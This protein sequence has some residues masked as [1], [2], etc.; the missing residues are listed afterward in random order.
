MLPQVYKIN[1]HLDVS[2]R[3]AVTLSF[4]NVCVFENTGFYEG[5][6]LLYFVKDVTLV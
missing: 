6:Y 1:T 5:E 3:S 2:T 4:S